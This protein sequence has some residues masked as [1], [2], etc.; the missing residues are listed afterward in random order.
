M[1]SEVAEEALLSVFVSRPEVLDLVE[2][3]GET[4]FTAS[5]TFRDNMQRNT[6]QVS[7]LKK[8]SSRGSTGSIFVQ[9]MSVPCVSHSPIRTHL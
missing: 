4:L 6:G 3:D 9:Q 8:R 5:K 7:R 2:L 1:T